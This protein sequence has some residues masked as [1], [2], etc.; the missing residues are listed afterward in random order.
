L[1][2]FI[3]ANDATARLVAEGWA[4]GL[5]PRILSSIVMVAVAL[6]ALG[7]GR[8][9]FNLL[10]I[11]GAGILAWEWT[12]LCGG[13]RFGWTGAIQATTV[14]A[15]VAAAILD[16]PGIGVTLV[17]A[18]IVGGYIAARVSGRDHP[19]WIA[20]GTVY[21]GLPCMALVW[22]RAGPSGGPLILWLLLCVWA[23][24]IGAFFAGRLIGGPRLAPRLSPKK[25]W[26]GLGGGALSAA[27]VGWVM[28]SIDGQAPPAMVL[29]IGG[30]LLAVIAQAGD[31]GESWVK[32]R[33]GVKDAS[34]L[35]PGHGGLFDRVDGLLTA[36]L[37]LA[38]W[39]WAAGAA[40][41]A[42]R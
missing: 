21:I 34:Q 26:A 37:A 33:F 16:R 40:A 1:A 28:A 10:V 31:L 12:R 2:S 11:V 38:V 8:I 6:V 18:G 7:A 25:T 3:A 14:V 24:D 13:G 32:R 23:T 9:G 19:R 4:A 17:A 29:A 42:W 22:L 15:V 30:A 41:L 35:I 5:R 36:A 20:A 27:I 39:Q